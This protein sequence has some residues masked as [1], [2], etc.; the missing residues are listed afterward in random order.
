M[1]MTIKNR[2]MVLGFSTVFMT[3]LLL[4]GFSAWRIISR[5]EQE[6]AVYVEGAMQTKKQSIKD[7]MDIALSALKRANAEAHDKKRL[8]QSAEGQLK[9]SLETVYAYIEEQQKQVANATNKEKALEKAKEN[10]KQFIQNFR[11]GDKGE[12]Y[13]WIH[14]YPKRWSK[15]IMILDPTLPDL[16]GV[17][18][19]YFQYPQGPQKGDVVYAEDTAMATPVFV[20]MNRLV[21]D[22]GEGFV[23]YD[24][25]KPNSKGIGAYQTKLS[26]VRLFEPW[27]WV[28]GTG[29]YLSGLESRVKQDMMRMISEFRFGPGKDSY[30]WIHS[31]DPF[32]PDKPSMLMDPTLPEMRGED[33]A[34]FRYRF[35]DKKGE[36]VTIDK[37]NKKD[38][39]NKK[40][41]L[42]VRMNQLIQKE[43]GGFLHFEW[44][45]L[46]SAG[47]V[48]Q[49]PRLGYVQLFEEWQWVVGTAVFLNDIEAEKVK[50]KAM[51]AEEISHMLWATLLV[52]GIVIMLSYLLILFL[53]GKIIQPIL[54][55]SDCIKKMGENDLTSH[56]GTEDLEAKGELGIMARGYELTL[57]N[58]KK[59]IGHIQNEVEGV[60]SASQRFSE[61]NEELSVRTEKQAA[62]LEE[63]SAAVEELTATV[64]QNAD[65]ASQAHQISKEAK[66]ISD[67]ANGQLQSAVEQTTTTNQQ[68]VAH[69]KE[70]NKRFFE[71][72]QD[73][74]QETV[75]MMKGIAGSSKKI[76]G[77]TSVINDIAFQT[78]LLAINASVEAARAGEHGRGF[79]VVASE[80]RKLASRSAKASKEI[81]SLIHNNI[82]QIQTNVQTADEASQSL[83]KLQ[84]DISEKLGDI[85]EQLSKSLGEL[86][87]QVN[88]NLREITDAVTKVSDVVEN[89]SAA[90]MEQAE[91]IRQVNIAIID[92]EKI[93]HQN[94]MLADET[95]TTSRGLVDQAQTLLNEVYNFQV[96]EENEAGGNLASDITLNQNS[97][98][99]TNTLFSDSD[100]PPVNSSPRLLKKVG[101]WQDAEKSDFE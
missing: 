3:V 89:I 90:S 17:K 61:G 95:V 51:V 33:L 98:V 92:M 31:F 93:T 54:R 34:D 87:E 67:T 64:Q 20:Q 13:V 44:P 72:V 74:S 21:K 39:N 9:A 65:N 22:K 52:S 7:V 62:A 66:T 47:V 57:L 83:S 77:I 58:I 27:G 49:Q 63:T 26:Y 42:F 73:T 25:P 68:I 37:K 11:L 69:I 50:K 36:L 85:E 1:K 10:A 76:S 80:V 88:L 100:N 60:V 12:G 5:G 91:G 75:A 94:A 32:A 84:Q 6:V 16:Q 23:S 15:P 86:G 29:V 82:E 59:I 40:I 53:S 24:W 96:E 43:K 30:F 55:I 101:S 46:V 41:P 38:K 4:G 70:A 18:L 14:S 19:A 48:K 97:D 71:R 79:A 56:L 2:I 81:G 35:G 28:L 78:N 99:D 8:R 45:K